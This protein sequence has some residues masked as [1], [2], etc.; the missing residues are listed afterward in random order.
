ML[1]QNEHGIYVGRPKVFDQRT[2]QLMIEDLSAQLAAIKSVDQAKIAGAIGVLQGMEIRETGVAGSLAIKRPYTTEVT[3]DGKVKVTE[4]VPD[5]RTA[6]TSGLGEATNIPMGTPTFGMASQDLLSEQINL[7]YQIFN[8]RMINDRSLTDRIQGDKSKLQ[9]VIGIPVSLDPSRHALDSAAIVKVR[10]KMTRPTVPPSEPKKTESQQPATEAPQAQQAPT[11]QRWGSQTSEL[12]PIA[13]PQSQQ[14]KYIPQPLPQ[15]VPIYQPQTEPLPQQQAIQQSVDPDA[16][17]SV[18]ALMP[19]EKTYNSATLSKSAKSFSGSAIAKVV[20]VGFTATKRGQTYFLYKDNDTISFEHPIAKRPTKEEATKGAVPTPEHEV[21]FGWQFRPVLGRRSV[22]PG[23]RQMFAVLALPTPDAGTE[24][25]TLHVEV[26]TRWVKYQRSQLTVF[27]TTLWYETFGESIGKPRTPPDPDKKMAFTVKVPTTD[28]Y[29]T[30]LAPSVE[31]VGWNM[32]GTKNVIISVQGSNFLSDTKIMMGGKTFDTTNGVKIKSEKAFDLTV[33]SAALS[34]AVIQGRYG[35]SVPML[36][37]GV[38]AKQIEVAKV[39]WPPA[40]DQFLSGT[41]YLTREGGLSITDLPKFPNLETKKADYLTPFLTFSGVPIPGPFAFQ[42][43]GLERD[44][45]DP[46]KTVAVTFGIPGDIAKKGAGHLSYSYPFHGTAWTTSVPIGDNNKMYFASRIKTGIKKGWT[47]LTITDTQ[48]LLTQTPDLRVILP[49]KELLMGRSPSSLKLKVTSDIKRE[50]SSQGPSERQETTG[51]GRT[52]VQQPSEQDKR[53]EQASTS[54]AAKTEEE[55]S[56]QECASTNQD[57]FKD[58]FCLQDATVAILRLNTEDIG[59][60]I[61]LKRNN[62]VFKVIVPPA[63]K[64]A[65]VAKKLEVN[66]YDS[67]WLSLEADYATVD[68]VKADSET[69]V[70]RKNGEKTDVHITRKLTEKPG[71]ID[72]LIQSIIEGKP[73]AGKVVKLDIICRECQAKEA[74]K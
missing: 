67:V 12:V 72:L 22:A 63:E 33:D 20:E 73:D 41:I 45:K 14:P 48:S 6:L 10:V 65:E 70:K 62:T 34:G 53:A 66:Q 7:Q 19:Q 24:P 35:N 61:V 37:T 39:L 17:L 2:L 15:P 13:L 68:S 46:V 18:V 5:P 27:P 31:K 26:E 47:V 8:L 55:T 60:E 64:K 21:A 36:S 23:M 32:V 56:N 44:G 54:Q 50:T 4:V 9:A 69:L 29:Q 42:D 28:G 74:K 43:V 51:S 58:A 3:D 11:T 16:F 1:G 25:A 40:I 30:S 71:S 38:D 57:T 59:E 52:R 49:T